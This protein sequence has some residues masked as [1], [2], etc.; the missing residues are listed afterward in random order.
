MPPNPIR[1]ARCSEYPARRA[2]P[3][4]F[5]PLQVT[6]L[7]AP[8]VGADPL[9][10]VSHHFFAGHGPPRSHHPTLAAE[11][12]LHPREQFPRPARSG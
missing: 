12:A 5:R 11:P 1:R 10:G 3:G 9:D 7:R 8:N 6:S 2:Y 4:W